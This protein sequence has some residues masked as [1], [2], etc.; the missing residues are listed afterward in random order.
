ILTTLRGA[1]LVSRSQLDG[2]YLPGPGLV[3]L[4]S[5]AAQHLEPL[6][7]FDMLAADMVEQLGETVLLWIQQG[8]GLAMAAARD[9]TQPLRYVPPLGLRLPATGF[10]S[11]ARDGVVEG[12]LEPGV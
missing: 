1:G 10:A 11:R 8:D 12:E 3:A 5:A 6:H 7:A 4:G 2:R 9:G